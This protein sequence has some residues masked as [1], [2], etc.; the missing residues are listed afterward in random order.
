MPRTSPHV[1]A[2]AACLVFLSSCGND[3]RR[4]GSGAFVGGA[5][6]AMAGA[7]CCGNPVDG[8]GKGAIIGI[9]VGAIVGFILDMAM[10]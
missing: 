1:A 7:L 8:T 10:D 9:A 3:Y 5:T 2:L 4:T 6:G